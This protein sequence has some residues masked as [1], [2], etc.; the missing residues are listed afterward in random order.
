MTKQEEEDEKFKSI[1]FV[2]N[3]PISG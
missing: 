1:F 2:I 3:F